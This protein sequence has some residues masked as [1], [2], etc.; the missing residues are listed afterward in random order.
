MTCIDGVS[1]DIVI[2]STVNH[3]D[4]TTIRWMEVRPTH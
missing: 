2:D 3:L 1:E 4:V